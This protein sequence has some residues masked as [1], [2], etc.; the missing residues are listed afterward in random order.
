MAHRRATVY[1]Y[2]RIGPDDWRYAKPSYSANGKIKPNVVVVGNRSETHTEGNYYLR[3]HAGKGSWRKIGPNAA[4][5]ERAAQY[6][7]SL[8]TAIA[9]GIP[10]TRRLEEPKSLAG[11]L[12]GFLEDYKLSQ[13]PESY[14]LM[15]QTRDE[16][17]EFNKKSVI[18]DIT[19]VDLLKYKQWLVNRG[20]T[21]RTAGNKMLRVNQYL[22]SIQGL[23]PGKGLVTT[24]DAKFVQLEPEVY[25][26][27]E[28]ALFFAACTPF[29]FLVFKTY[30]MSGLRKQELENLEWTD[31]NFRA[32]SS[33]YA[34]NQGG[35]L[36]LGR[37]ARLKLPTIF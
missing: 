4:D 9:H 16:F 34:P 27:E 5:A 29:Q 15:K 24:K 14:N 10:V 37:S 26:P 3:L 11:T 31:I 36:K 32:A 30:L 1:K 2:I 6:E 28:L 18:A 7:E 25:A 22:R 13:R 33:R 21:V 8:L 12:W 23:E 17:V 20:R 35:Y 19:R